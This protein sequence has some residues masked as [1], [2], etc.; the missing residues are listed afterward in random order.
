MGTTILL[1]VLCVAVIMLGGVGIFFLCEILKRQDRAWGGF[2]EMKRQYQE[3]DERMLGGGFLKLA[4]TLANETKGLLAREG[5]ASDLYQ[6]A[7]VLR[8]T[9]TGQQLQDL[10]SCLESTSTRRT[11]VVTELQQ[12]GGQIWDRELERV[13]TLTE[14]LRTQFDAVQV[15]HNEATADLNA[16]QA[17]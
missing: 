16:I 11:R 6:A 10:G 9:I 17:P 2:L 1:V 8:V 12:T 4:E 15:L 7:A 13:D 5:L 14:R 3:D